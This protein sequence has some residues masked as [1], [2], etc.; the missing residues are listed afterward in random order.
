MSTNKRASPQGGAGK[1][2]M[3]GRRTAKVGPA[4]TRTHMECIERLAHSKRE[5][6]L[7]QAPF[8]GP[9][10]AF[11]RQPGP[12]RLIR[13]PPAAA[14]HESAAKASGGG[15]RGVLDA[16]SLPSTAPPGTGGWLERKG[17]WPKGPLE[18]KR[19]VALL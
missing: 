18:P 17:Q 9:H 8:P 2:L 1:G 15:G 11:C 13:G 12:Q 6:R 16:P 7:S 4:R 14:F 3:R 19:W 5:V 10:Q